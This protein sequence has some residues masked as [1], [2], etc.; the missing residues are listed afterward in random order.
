[1][2]AIKKAEARKLVMSRMS[3]YKTKMKKDLLIK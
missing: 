3:K 2:K 1:M